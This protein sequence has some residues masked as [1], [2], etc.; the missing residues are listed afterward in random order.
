M[1]VPFI[2]RDSRRRFDAAMHRRIRSFTP[3]YWNPRLR[4]G[5]GHGWTLDR[6]LRHR[7]LDI[8]VAVALSRPVLQ[9]ELPDGAWMLNAAPA[10]RW[11]IYWTDNRGLRRV[12]G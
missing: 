12:V 6:L 9:V 5:F 8:S 4:H 2:S 7:G 11:R 1:V 10:G 3:D